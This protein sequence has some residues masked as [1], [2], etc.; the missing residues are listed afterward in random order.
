ML[1]KRHDWVHLICAGRDERF[2]DIPCE[3]FRASS[4]QCTNLTKISQ[5]HR[6]FH[7]MEEIGI[8]VRGILFNPA[9][10]CGLMEKMWENSRC[11]PFQV[12]LKAVSLSATSLQR[13][14]GHGLVDSEEDIDLRSLVQRLKRP[15]E[16][17]NGCNLSVW[18]AY[19]RKAVDNEMLGVLRRRGVILRHESCRACAHISLSRP[20]TCT[21]DVIEPMEGD[22]RG[23]RANPYYGMERKR[24]DPVCAG[25]SAREYVL[26]CVHS[27]YRPDSD[28]SRDLHP[29]ET[30]LYVEELTFLL[31]KR[32][33]KSPK[34]SKARQ[35]CGRQL[36][37]FVILLS[38]LKDH[39]CTEQEAFQI[40][41]E[42]SG[43]NR[44]MIQR[45][46][47]EIRMFL[48]DA[49]EK[50]GVEAMETL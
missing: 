46:F 48:K 10:G 13:S 19:I 6:L 16:L 43:M 24:R 41:A 39:E 29:S 30:R 21:L 32:F 31:K 47:M 45:D 5:C 15:V 11:D 3:D 38:L 49:I 44:K 33:E 8:D 40:L 22:I 12:M 14:Y 1:D 26:P 28:P 50:E 18:A 34:A 2:Q 23:E 42:T 35:K 4:G 36:E 27:E 20:F 9:H 7:S 37:L 25:Y 17:R